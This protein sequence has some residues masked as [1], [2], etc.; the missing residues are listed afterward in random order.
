MRL[1]TIPIHLQP[2]YQE[3][4]YRGGEYPVTEVLGRTSIA[5]PF[6]NNLT[7][8]EVVYVAEVLEGAVG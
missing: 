3:F 6:H 5:I 7:R 2:F 1:I 8:E 4:G